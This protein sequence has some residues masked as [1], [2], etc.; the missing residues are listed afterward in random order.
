MISNVIILEFDRNV[1]DNKPWL[2]KKGQTSPRKGKSRF[3]IKYKNKQEY[4]IEW[5]RVNKEKYRL[6]AI[7]Q[8]ERQKKRRL[9]NP[10]PFKIRAKRCYYKNRERVL[11]TESERLVNMRLKIHK[12][13]NQNS[14]VYCGY[15]TWAALQFDHIN[16]GGNKMRR[17]FNSGRAMYRYYIKNPDITKKELQIVCA[18]CNFIKRDKERM[19]NHFR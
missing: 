7:G 3:D 15:S 1:M 12:I 11:K 19:V 17:E 4:Q 14:C 6:Q 8:N 18:N 5:R 16:G 9:I 2:F 13:L 10:E